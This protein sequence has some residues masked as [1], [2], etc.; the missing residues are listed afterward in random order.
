MRL[1]CRRTVVC[2]SGRLL[3]L[4]WLRIRLGPAAPD[5]RRAD[6][7]DDSCG[8]AR[9][10]RWR[11]GAVDQS[12]GNGQQSASVA[13]V[14]RAESGSRDPADDDLLRADHHRF[15]T[16][17]SGDRIAV[18]ATEPG[19]D[20]RGDVHDAVRDDAGLEASLRRGD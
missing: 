3:A 12:R 2:S 16:L 13:A 5:D 7:P 8:N 1:V 6:A 18:A 20:Q 14:D 15:G 11:S 10:A 17:A 4:S 19:D 9:H